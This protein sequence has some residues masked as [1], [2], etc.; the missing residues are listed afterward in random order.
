MKELYKIS[1]FFFALSG[2]F[3]Y[4]SSFFPK[5]CANMCGPGEVC[6]LTAN[7]VVSIWGVLTSWL[8]GLV[9]ILAVGYLIAGLFQKKKIN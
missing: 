2:I 3:Y 8:G 1:I 9:L 4:V 6:A 5:G 7:C